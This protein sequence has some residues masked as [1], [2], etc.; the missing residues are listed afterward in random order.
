V[1]TVLVARQGLLLEETHIVNATRW[2]R[3]TKE[4]LNAVRAGLGPRAL[5][6]V[7]P[8]LQPDVSTV[9]TALLS[10]WHLEFVWET[11][12]GTIRDVTVDET[13]FRELAALVTDA[14]AARALSLYADAPHRP[15]WGRE[16]PAARPIR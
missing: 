7:W 16:W 1:C 8:D 5:L 13:Q 14:R 4:N 10:E 12:D 9:L 3:L 2:H 15:G 6:T 11:K